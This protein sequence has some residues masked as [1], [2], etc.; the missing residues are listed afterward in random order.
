M[1]LL[2]KAQ[3]RAFGGGSG[4]LRRG[5]DSLYIALSSLVLTLLQPVGHFGF[6]VSREESKSPNAVTR[7]GSSLAGMAPVVGPK[8]VT[9]PRFLQYSKVLW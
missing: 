7:Q 9:L 5:M 3:R 1:P 6:S 4:Y 2:L 8:H